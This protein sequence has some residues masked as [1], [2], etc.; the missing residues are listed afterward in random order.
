MTPAL[1]PIYPATI[2]AAAYREYRSLFEAVSYGEARE[3]I[4]R[5]W[6]RDA[7]SAGARRMI[8]HDLGIVAKDGQVITVLRRDNPAQG[9][10][11]LF[12][13]EG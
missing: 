7:V 11:G 1:T 4:L 5:G 8:R 9:I 6:V 3:R 2:S 13:R 12:G 10:I